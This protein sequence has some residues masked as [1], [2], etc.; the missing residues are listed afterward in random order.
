MVTYE[1]LPF[2][3]A[4]AEKWPSKGYLPLVSGDLGETERREN[5]EMLVSQ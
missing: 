2:T 1:V 3:E 5:S 4:G